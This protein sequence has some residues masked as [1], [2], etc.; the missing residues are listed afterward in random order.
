MVPAVL[1]N[2][3]ALSA[4]IRYLYTVPR[5]PEPNF[6]TPEIMSALDAAVL[7]VKDTYLLNA[8]A[9]YFSRS[10]RGTGCDQ[11]VYLTFLPSTVYVEHSL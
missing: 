1:W 5:H 7:N 2:D 3:I 10:L 8:L 11:A 9:K 4:E 6:L